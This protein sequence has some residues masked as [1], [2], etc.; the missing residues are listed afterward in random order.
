MDS[1]DHSFSFISK[2]EKYDNKLWNFH[3]K[4][5]IDIVGYYKE[6]KIVRLI[7]LLNEEHSIMCA[8]MPA[9]QG[10]YFIKINSDIR[11][12]LN[13]HLGDQLRL[14]LSEDKSP[15]GMPLPIEMSELFEQEPLFD[16]YF[17]EL[18][19]G[20][21]RALL[22]IIEKIKNPSKRLEKAVIISQYMIMSKGQLDYKELNKAFKQGL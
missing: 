12:I 10:E 22:Y 21:Q 1:S 16:R 8:M 17:H 5:P 18:T 6:N 4:I 7:C 11:K 9:G 2:F 14:T 3:F 15:Y 19:P 13:L 20:K